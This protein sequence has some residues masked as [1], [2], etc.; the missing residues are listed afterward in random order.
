MQR[1]SSIA[2]A[3][4]LATLVLSSSSCVSQARYEEALT[5]AKYYQ[6][7]YQD[8]EAYQVQLKAEL[9]QARANS[10]TVAPTEAGFTAEID[11]R[12]AELDRVA[13]AIGGAPSDLEVKPVEGGYMLRVSDAALFDS[14]SAELKGE[15]KELLLKSAKEI[16]SQPYGRI[17]V[18]GHTDSDPVKKPTTLAKFPLGNLDLS[19]ER[20]KHVASLLANEGGLQRSKIVVAGF[21]PNDPLVP[22][23]S[24]INK[25]RNRR[26]EI[27]VL[28]RAEEQ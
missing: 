14:A 20:A 27:F 16:Q 4:G 3:L 25:A 6:R 10:S 15:G 5:E 12:L 11:E 24:A 17:W 23:T 22:N 7:G 18:R 9:E 26:V 8:L 28:E 2:F 21:G 1:R 19:L 13:R